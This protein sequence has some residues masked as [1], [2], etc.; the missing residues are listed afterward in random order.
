MIGSS[1]CFEGEDCEGLGRCEPIWLSSKLCSADLV[2]LFA[3]VLRASSIERF[4]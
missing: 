2:I 4:G 3:L 1:S